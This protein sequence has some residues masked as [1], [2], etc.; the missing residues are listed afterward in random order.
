MFPVFLVPIAGLQLVRTELDPY[1]HLRPLGCSLFLSCITPRPCDALTQ[2]RSNR[3]RRGQCWRRLQLCRSWRSGRPR[4][5]FFARQLPCSLPFA[6]QLPAQVISLVP[7]VNN[8]TLGC[9]QRH[10]DIAPVNP[11]STCS[12]ELLPRRHPC[13][14]MVSLMVCASA[15]HPSGVGNVFFGMCRRASFTGIPAAGGA[16]RGWLPARP[17]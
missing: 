14:S 3:C 6:M 4:A 1:R 2:I 10:A 5:P 13:A 17:G 7:D 12:E 15:T 16:G 8:N 9:P 11:M